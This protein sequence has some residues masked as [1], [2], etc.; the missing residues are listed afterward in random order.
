[1]VEAARSAAARAGAAVKFVEGRFE[2]K[3]AGIG[4]FDVVTIGRAIHWLDPER[5]KRRSIASSSRAAGLSSATP[6]APT[7]AA[8]RGFR[9][10][11]RCATAG[12][13]S[14]RPLIATVF[15]PA[16]PSSSAGRSGSSGRDDHGRAPR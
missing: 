5:R 8:T 4:G 13:P 12:G 16:D 10:S 15:S 11:C 3:A 6:R 2:D 1:M 14:D 7:T 9:P